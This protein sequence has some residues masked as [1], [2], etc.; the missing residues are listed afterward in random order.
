MRDR[1]GKFEILQP[2]G[3]GAMGDVYLAKDPMIGRHVAVK[4][5]RPDALE[6]SNRRE[7]VQERFFR[8]ARAA[9]G[10]NHRNIVT[11][12]EFGEDGDLLYLAMEFV[13]GE[14]LGT[15][16]E[17]GNLTAAEKLEIL[18]QVCDGLAHA[19]AKG[20]LHRD[21]KPSNI[22]VTLED[23]KLLAKVMDFGIARQGGSDL[24]GTGTLV[25][26]FSYMA[27]EYIQGGKASAASDL[28][29]V[30]VILYEALAGQ[31]AFKG[32]SGA[33]LLY[34]IVHQQPERIDPE[35][36][37]GLSPA[38]QALVDR[39]LAK[40]PA[41]RLP[42]A[43]AFA[44]A[45]RAAK[46]PAWP[47]LQDWQED[48]TREA[49]RPLLPAGPVRAAPPATPAPHPTPKAPVPI[50]LTREAAP[51]PARPWAWPVGA[52][53]IL[54]LAGGLWWLNRTGPPPASA[55]PAAP[56]APQVPRPPA[57][58]G[59]QARAGEPP[60]GAPSPAEPGAPGPA[61][62]PRP[63]ASA[64]PAGGTPPPP[65]RPQDPEGFESG[66]RQLETD[67]ERALS[68]L[69]QALR[70]VPG[71]VPSHATRLYALFRLNRTREL[72]AALDEAREAGVTPVQMEGIPHYR[73]LLDEARRTRRL[74]PEILGALTQGLT[75]PGPPGGGPPGGGPPRS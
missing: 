61:E 24:T 22:R 25:G 66:L 44:A 46:D 6:L 23:G 26:T 14:D 58:P 68:D 15:L 28:F 7:V 71:H 63:D 27:P 34:S 37:E 54:L 35:R 8:E 16:F 12:H 65:P 53:A 38:V 30:G 69:E 40:D 47:G 42:D 31:R 75:Q 13:D 67:P 39:A 21:I 48:A 52:G 45:L 60:S 57:R 41:W 62:A 55:A 17:Q 20:I 74:S 10:L 19:H 29:A 33:T 2:L 5:I 3:H 36:I 9:G 32:D 59:A 50:I 49:G 56:V 70:E 64:P 18:A 72:K 51:G 11:I 1:I 4:V 43:A 73:R